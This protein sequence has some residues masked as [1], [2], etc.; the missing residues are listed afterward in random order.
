MIVYNQPALPMSNPVSV[1]SWNLLYQ[2]RPGH[3]PGVEDEVPDVRDAG[4][5]PVDAV[6]VGARVGLL[7]RRQHLALPDGVHGG[8]PVLAPLRHGGHVDEGDGHPRRRRAGHVGRRVEHVPVR[9][10]P[11]RPVPVEQ[12]HRLLGAPDPARVPPHLRAAE[13]RKQIFQKPS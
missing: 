1:N 10:Q 2:L 8:V 12:R 6:G 9:A 13:P 5:A 4:E 7:L 11:D 3:Y